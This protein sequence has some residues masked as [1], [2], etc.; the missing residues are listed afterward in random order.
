MLP[1]HKI[2]YL[3]AVFFILLV[4]GIVVAVFNKKTV[5]VSPEPKSG[6][7]PANIDVALKNAR[8]NEVRNGVAVWELTADKTEYDQ[9]G[10]IA[11]LTGV[12]M[13]F[14][15]TSFGKIILTAEKAHYSAKT[16]DVQLRKNIKVTTEN[17]VS[18][19][20]ESLDYDAGRSEFRTDEQVTF[21]QNRLSLKALGMKMFINNQKAKFGSQV[22]ARVKGLK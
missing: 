16:R 6:Q 7:L 18:F 8:F 11:D 10:E 17:G 2:R 1:L 4:I 20:T 13:L 12:K 15:K 21:H 9:T 5:Q 14:R 19:E 22:D 3:L